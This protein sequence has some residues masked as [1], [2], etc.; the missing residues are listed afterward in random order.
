M[1]KDEMLKLATCFMIAEDITVEK[2][3]DEKWCVLV[4]G[5]SVLDKD[6]NRIYEP[7]PSNRSEEFI[8]STRF[9]L[10]DA[11]YLALEYKEKIY[12]QPE[13]FI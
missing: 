9:S 11:F 8:K 3:G 7:S 13:I 10:N 6:M 12:N 1:T 2:R 5:Q 4:F